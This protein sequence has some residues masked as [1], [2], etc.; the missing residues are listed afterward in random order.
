MQLLS[1]NL[2][3]IFDRMKVVE[4]S[5]PS[6]AER[7]VQIPRIYDSQMHCFG[8]ISKDPDQLRTKEL[9]ETKTCDIPEP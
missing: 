6:N 5:K 4:I 1:N 8:D 2:E 9:E 3:K 7:E